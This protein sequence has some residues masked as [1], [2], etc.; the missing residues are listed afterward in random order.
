M[1][2]EKVNTKSEIHNVLKNEWM[3][4]NTILEDSPNSHIEGMFQIYNEYLR[5]KEIE[6]KFQDGQMH[7]K[8]GNKCMILS[9]TMETESDFHKL[10]VKIVTSLDKSS[11]DRFLNT[12]F[13][14]NSMLTPLELICK[15]E[16]TSLFRLVSNMITIDI[17]RPTSENKPL[18]NIGSPTMKAQLLE[19][20][21]SFLKAAN[22]KNKIDMAKTQTEYKRR[23]LKNNILM[24]ICAIVAGVSI[25]Y[26]HVC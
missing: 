22:L 5:D 8:L 13:F 3:P 17:Y 7:A 14:D 26:G 12:R 9:G 18:L 10:V 4:V 19:Y 11:L 23:A 15:N 21:N 2:F 16:F 20:E 25:L 6:L 24:A 1:H